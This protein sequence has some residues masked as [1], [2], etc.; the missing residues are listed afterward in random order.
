MD[1]P[2][3]P[4]RG[5]RV[6]CANRCGVVGAA[7]PACARRVCP[8][9][10]AKTR[11]D[12]ACVQTVARP[13]RAARCAEQGRRPRD[14]AA[15]GRRCRA[16][17]LHSNSCAAPMRRP[18]DPGSPRTAALGLPLTCT[19]LRALR[20]LRA[21]PRQWGN[22][23]ACQKPVDV[24]RFTENSSVETHPARLAARWTFAER[25]YHVERLKTRSVSQARF[26]GN[27]SVKANVS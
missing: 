16:D 18:R 1:A 27:S 10:Y 6:V 20:G 24:E 2:I 15:S 25:T 8:L 14:P 23:L 5:A 4:Q 13:G 11:G 7:S 22:G 12:V 21:A 26:V 19:P 3:C 17:G 9:S